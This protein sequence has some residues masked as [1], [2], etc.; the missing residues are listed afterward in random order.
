M[1]DDGVEDFLRLSK[2][3]KAAGRTELRKE[4]NKAM[5][6]AVKPL[7]PKTRARALATLPQRGGLAKSVARTPQRVQ[8]RTG[9]QTAGVRLVVGRNGSGARGANQGSIRHPVFGDPDVWVDQSVPS[10]WFDDTVEG[11]FPQIRRAVEKAMKSIA[12]QVV[13]DARR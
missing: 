2:A 12:E 13:R 11:E 4:L 6:G 7:I 5:R 8:V 9:L 1:A 10:G 3:L